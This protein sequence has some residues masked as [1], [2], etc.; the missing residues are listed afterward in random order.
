MKQIT[1]NNKISIMKANIRTI[2]LTAFIVFGAVTSSL[3]QRVITGTVYSGG[4]PASGITVEAHRGGEMMTSFDGK[5]KVEADEK[6]KWLKFTSLALGETK[7]LDIDELQ[8]D[9]FNF[10][11][12]KGTLAAEGGAEES[13]DEGEVV[14]KTL[15]ELMSEQ[16]KDFMNELSLYTEFYKQEDYNSA[17]PHWRKVY[18]KYPKS[19]ENVY[20]QGIKMYESLIENSETPEER[21]KNID[22]LMK[23]YDKRIKYFGEKGYNLGRKATAWLEYKLG[24][25][26]NLE[27]DQM[28]DALKQ[29]YEWISESIEE[30]G[31]DTELPVL[32]LLMQTSK[33]LFKL[34]ELPKETVVKNYNIATNTLNT[35]VEKGDDEKRV[36]DAN[37]IRPYIED[38]F[39][40]SGAADCEALISIF[41]PQYEENKQDVDF[42]KN[43]LRRL[44]RADCGESRLFS[45]ATE[46]LYQL[47][48]SAEAAFNMARRYVQRD[49]AEKAKEYYLQAMEQETNDELLATYFYEYA[50]F[51]FAKEQALQE[52][53]N[54]A[55]KA[56]DLNPQ[57]CEALMLI[58]DIYVA[59]S[60]NYG[61]DDFEKATVFW[62]AVDYF[63]RARRAGDDCAV[64]A[65]QKA[66]TYRKYFPNKEEGFFRSLQEGQAYTVGGWINEPTKI[67]Y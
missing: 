35:I 30:R 46:Q 47:E 25:N 1:K 60:R 22:Q 40:T 2:L 23:I 63:E 20:I 37:E 62:T 44:R 15:Q 38:I 39:G 65:A 24:P 14:L 41:K 50:L 16:D 19:T 3:A 32:L 6:T 36:S 17:L 57:Y 42:I 55:K 34:G 67:R 4:E 13:V 61:E 33:S 45:N 53:R 7:R 48:P 9:Q 31:V 66:N 11:Y 12:D 28:K 49:D 21:Q 5:Y 29:G 58:G 26:S 8:G 10:D 64:D 27:G 51:V 52:A 43:M 54:Y 56:L 59:A 18:N